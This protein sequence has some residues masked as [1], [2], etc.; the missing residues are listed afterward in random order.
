MAIIQ[1]IRAD[2]IVETLRNLWTL[3]KGFASFGM[4]KNPKISL[5]NPG[6]L[7]LPFGVAVAAA[8][9]ACFCVAYW[10]AWKRIL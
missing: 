6:L 10:P 3:I 8:T 1:M 7:K 4:I 2:R 5:D 9:I